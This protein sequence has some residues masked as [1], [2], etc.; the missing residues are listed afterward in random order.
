MRALE[1]GED[2]E[3]GPGANSPQSGN[4]EE[5]DDEELSNYQNQL[6]PGME[7]DGENENSTVRNDEGEEPTDAIVPVG[8]VIDHSKPIPMP[9]P[10]RSNGGRNEQWPCPACTFINPAYLVTCEI[11]DAPKAS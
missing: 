2:G 3:F 9:P 5:E 7:E 11:C 4:R 6:G 1:E 8:G 10:N